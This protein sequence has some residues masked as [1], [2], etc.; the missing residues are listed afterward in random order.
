MRGKFGGIYYAPQRDRPETV[1][2]ICITGKMTEI[3]RALYE[4][5]II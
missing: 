5:E 3:E 2:F 1:F 4:E